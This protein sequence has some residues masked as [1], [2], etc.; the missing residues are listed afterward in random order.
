M[1]FRISRP[2]RVSGWAAI[3]LGLGLLSA[4]AEESWQEGL[5]RE[6][7]GDA[8]GAL[9]FYE[10]WLGTNPGDPQVFEVLKRFLTLQPNPEAFF[11]QTDKDWNLSGPQRGEI[12]RWAGRV[13]ELARNPEK[14]KEYYTRAYN[15]HP[16]R[17]NL[18]LLLEAAQMYLLMGEEENAQGILAFVRR[19]DGAGTFAAPRLLLQSRIAFFKDRPDEAYAFWQELTAPQNAGPGGLPSGAFVWGIALCRALGKDAEARTWEIS[20]LAEYPGEARALLEGGWEA[21]LDPLSV[22]GLSYPEALGLGPPSGPA[23]QP[24]EGGSSSPAAPGA[25]AAQGP[26]PVFRQIQTGS[27]RDRD[28]ARQQQ[29]ALSRLGFYPEIRESAVDNRPLYRVVIT[30]IPPETLTETLNRLR[31]NGLEGFTL[32]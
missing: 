17:E 4:G 13:A 11:A 5:N 8:V 31:Q 6:Q 22:F 32:P 23:H 19:E 1:I 24:G 18:Y 7:R 25:G 9:A 27:F 28:N 30:R 15:A 26:A 12:L 14:A 2:P 21:P 29:D 10:A 3:L 20:F 16:Y